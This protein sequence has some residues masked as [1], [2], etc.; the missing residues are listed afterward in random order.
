MVSL[1]VVPFVVVPFSFNELVVA[2]S[3]REVVSAA[4]PK[5]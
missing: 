3:G 1:K 5:I 2:S 4:D